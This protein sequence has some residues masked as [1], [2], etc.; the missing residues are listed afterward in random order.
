[1]PEKNQSSFNKKEDRYH[2]RTASSIGDTLET[3]RMITKGYNPIDPLERSRYY[4]KEDC[5]SHRKE[6]S[7]LYRKTNL[8]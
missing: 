6:K 5:S 2:D 8:G 3:N 1:M 4:S 7:E